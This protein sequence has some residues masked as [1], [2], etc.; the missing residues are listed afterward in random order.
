MIEMA[1]RPGDHIDRLSSGIYRMQ[2]SRRI[3]ALNRAAA[4]SMTPRQSIRR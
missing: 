1:Q 2:G 3:D 4:F